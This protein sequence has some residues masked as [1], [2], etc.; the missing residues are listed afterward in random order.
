MSTNARILKYLQSH[1]VPC[2][3]VDGIVCALDE[4]TLD[5]VYGARLVELRTVRETLEFLGY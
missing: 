1:C 2:H 4:Y 5:G 3:E